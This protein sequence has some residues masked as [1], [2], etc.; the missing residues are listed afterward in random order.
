M[1]FAS[2]FLLLLCLGCVNNKVL[3]L[4][5]DV[6]A[7]SI[8][9]VYFTAEPDLYPN[10]IKVGDLKLAYPHQSWPE[11]EADI[12]AKAKAH[13]GNLVHFHKFVQEGQYLEGSLYQVSEEVL[14]PQSPAPRLILFRDELGG[15]PSKNYDF[16]IEIQGQE[17]ELKDQ[18]VLY[19]Y[20]DSAHDSIPF[21]VKGEKGYLPIHAGDN[22]FWISHQFKGTQA[23][24]SIFLQYGGLQM[25]PIE[26]EDQAIAWLGS[27]KNSPSE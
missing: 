21:S 12:R 6:E 9:R 7:I 14:K 24:Q 18:E 3:N 8:D 2:I 19:L 25:K 22:Y 23:G 16:W 15:I 26:D 10:K 1:R 13:H 5:P 4:N 27:F 11:I 17:R 20:L